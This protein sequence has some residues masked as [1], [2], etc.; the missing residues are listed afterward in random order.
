MVLI[1]FFELEVVNQ[2]NP[3]HKHIDFLQMLVDLL[4][5]FNIIKHRVE[6]RVSVLQT[7]QMQL[8]EIF[9]IVYIYILI[10]PKQL[11]L[12][13]LVSVQ[14]SQPFLLYYIFCSGITRADV[15]FHEFLLILAQSQC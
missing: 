14:L 12:L 8:I 10:H 4:H 11:N 3:V 15:L 2:P 6:C 9:Q 5:F 1:L 7:I 13:I